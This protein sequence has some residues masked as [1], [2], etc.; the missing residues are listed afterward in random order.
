M[1]YNNIIAY[2][3]DYRKRILDFYY[4][5]G[6]TKTL[7]QFGISSST[8]YGWIKLHNETGDLSSRK[9]KRKFKVLDPEKL[10][11]YMKNPKNADKYIREIAKDFGC[12]K[13]TVRIALKNQ[14][15]Q[16]KKQTK[17]REQDERKVNEYLKK[18]SES[19]S[20]REIIYIDETGFDE[21]YYREYDCSKRGEYIE[22]RK[23]GLRYSRINLVAGKIG[24]ALIGSMIY[25]QTMESE[26]FEEWFRKIFL[27]DIEKL[28]KNVV[29]VLDNARFHRKRI[30]EKIVKETGHYLLFLPPYSPDLNPI[31][32]V[33]VSM[34][35]KLN[36]IARNF[37][38]LEEVV[39]SVLFDK[40]IPF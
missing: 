11:Q 2:E 17:Y 4:E 27:K 34:K 15:T 18:L 13:E 33:W 39:T 19:C 22:G 14:D 3:K 16:E 35:K 24:N 40:T 32:K 7:L 29:I 31:E 38:T 23:S 12:G 8:L 20:G 36:D 37:S 9:R 5:N 6:K 25:K 21:Y 28:K 1:W 30:L 26:F 10:D